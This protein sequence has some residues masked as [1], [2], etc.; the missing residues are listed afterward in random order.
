MTNR[1]GDNAACHHGL[2][3]AH[4]VCDQEAAVHGVQELQEGLEL[5]G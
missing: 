3:K 1:L 5:M 2:A 4:F